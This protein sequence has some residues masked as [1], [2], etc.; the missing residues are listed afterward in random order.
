M[1]FNLGKT[2]QVFVNEK[3]QNTDDFQSGKGSQVFIINLVK[4]LQIN[5]AAL[6]LSVVASLSFGDFKVG[7]EDLTFVLDLT[8]VQNLLGLLLKLLVMSLS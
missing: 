8:N 2:V 6:S 1:V 3:L 7:I 5:I 4:T